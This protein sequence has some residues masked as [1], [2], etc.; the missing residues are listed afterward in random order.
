MYRHSLHSHRI[1]RV[2]CGCS[3]WS[4]AFNAISRIA[5]RA[6]FSALG[7]ESINSTPALEQKQ[8]DANSFTLTRPRPSGTSTLSES[9][10]NRLAP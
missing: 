7:V 5:S 6:A 9:S 3:I 2:S 10:R 8:T 1:E 4:E